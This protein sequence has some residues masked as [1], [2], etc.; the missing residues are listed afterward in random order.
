[1]K[2][3]GP[4]IAKTIVVV[5]V[6]C[7]LKWAMGCPDSWLTLFLGVSVQVFLEEISIWNDGL[8]KADNSLQCGQVLSNLLSS[9][10]EQKVKGWPNSLSAWL[11]SWNINFLLPSVFLVLSLLDWTRKDTT[12]SPALRPLDYT[13]GF[14]GSPA[15]RWQIVG[16]PNLYNHMSQHVY[17]YVYVYVYLY[18]VNSVYLKNPDNLA[19]E[20]SWFFETS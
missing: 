9:W 1:M 16:L 20:Q 8:N 4:R 7:Q 3:R 6:M 13:T 10:I 2:I 11:L 19:K 14:P 18:P 15:C 5:N 17:V 12:G